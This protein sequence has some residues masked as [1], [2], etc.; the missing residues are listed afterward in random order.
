MDPI[1]SALFNYIKFQEETLETIKQKFVEG[2]SPAQ[3]KDA[4]LCLDLIQT[5]EAFYYKGI[6]YQEG[7]FVQ[8]DLVEAYQS[9]YK[10]S[11]RGYELAY[12]ELANC[13]QYGLGTEESAPNAFVWHKKNYEETGSVISGVYVA[14]TLKKRGD[15]S[16]Q[17]VYSIYQALHQKDLFSRYKLAE[18]F[19]LG[20]G[21][22]QDR[23]K[24]L[25]LFDQLY[26]EKAQIAQ[27]V[28]LFFLD[29][30]EYP[31]YE[32]YSKKL[33]DLGLDGWLNLGFV[34]EYGFGCEKSIEEALSYYKISA[35][36]GFSS[37]KGSYLLLSLIESKNKEAIFKDLKES[38]CDTCLMLYLNVIT[39][40]FKEEDVSF[41]AKNRF[42]P[43]LFYKK[44]RADLPQETYY[45][46]EKELEPLEG[47]SNFLPSLLLY[48]MY[49]AFLRKERN[50]ENS[51]EVKISQLVESIF[52]KIDETKNSIKLKKDQMFRTLEIALEGKQ[53]NLPE[54]LKLKYVEM[55]LSLKKSLEEVFL[56]E[57]KNLESSFRIVLTQLNN[58]S[59]IQLEDLEN[60]LSP[61][62]SY[63]F[64]YKFNTQ[65]FEKKRKEK[66]QSFERLKN[67]TL[68]KEARILEFKS[69]FEGISKVLGEQM[70]E[71]ELSYQ[72]QGDQLNKLRGFLHT[73][74]PEFFASTCDAME[75]KGSLEEIDLLEKTFFA[76]FEEMKTVL[77]VKKESVQESFLL[78]ERAFLE[79]EREFKRKEEETLKLLKRVEEENEALRIA[80]ESERHF[81]QEEGEQEKTGLEELI[82]QLTLKLEEGP[83]KKAIMGRHFYT[84]LELKKLLGHCQ[85]AQNKQTG[86]HQV[87]YI[88]G[89]LK[90]ESV[91]LLSGNDNDRIHV[92]GII[93][94]MKALLI[95]LK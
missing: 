80:L 76:T 64:Q 56:R 87:F 18:C 23:E 26:E 60:V 51:L 29:N 27:Y 45:F 79:R 3:I 94:V 48:K 2:A 7:R 73:E 62:K 63:I 53:Q 1:A 6:L 8:K 89:A 9:F 92:K 16:A 72:V 88:P 46:I 10:S 4:L 21:V 25:K 35:E 86:S 33:C 69:K 11:L 95:S 84:K 41:V 5:R 85:F 77:S 58:I 15:E 59:S 37:G 44:M 13:Y 34:K 78:K 54:S 50:I 70:K 74:A 90:K 65:S 24:A 91:V 32:E 28:P 39:I 71:R 61:I 68:K 19:F 82:S 38:E 66:L 93:Q 22:F 57:M 20:F 40:L 17:E 47:E 49:K 52:L 81:D 43:H 83:V 42:S 75:K 14:R 31:L 55:E 12:I 36:K 67:T 30:S